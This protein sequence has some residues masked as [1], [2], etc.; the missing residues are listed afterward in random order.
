MP[1]LKWD[2]FEARLTWWSSAKNSHGGG[3]GGI[4]GDGGGASQACSLSPI[5]HLSVN[6][7]HSQNL[8]AGHTEKAVCV[9][10]PA[11]GTPADSL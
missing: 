5:L 10:T 9:Y 8:N 11:V 4:G 2:A 6:V 7:F 1:S 3:A